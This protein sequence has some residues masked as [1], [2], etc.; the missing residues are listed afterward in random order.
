ME[1]FK[2]FIHWNMA[3]VEPKL[4]ESSDL[5]ERLLW[6]VLADVRANQMGSEV[7]SLVQSEPANGVELARLTEQ[8][9]EG[10]VRRIVADFESVIDPANPPSVSLELLAY[11]SIGAHHNAALRVSWDDRFSREELV[12]THLWIWLAL[13]AALS[14][15]VDIESRLARYKDLIKE[16]AAREP[17][18]PPAR[19]D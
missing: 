6:R 1:S 7:L 8:A 16:V 17:E 10:I 15:E 3:F 9:W 14:G 12:G 18:M 2:T 13:T 4:M 5:G 19:E 11:S